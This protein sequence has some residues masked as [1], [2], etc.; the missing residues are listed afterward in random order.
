MLDAILHRNEVLPLDAGLLQ[1]VLLAHG[2]PQT[3]IRRV[4][5]DLQ[6]VTTSQ[7]ALLPSLRRGLAGELAALEPWHLAHG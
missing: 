1:S 4:L 2:T 6:T 3:V 5:Q 7:N